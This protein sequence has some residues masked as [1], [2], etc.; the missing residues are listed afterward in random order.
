MS[1]VRCRERA[2]GRSAAVERRDRDVSVAQDE[3]RLYSVPARQTRLS[4]CRVQRHRSFAR[5]CVRVDQRRRAPASGAA[6]RH[7]LDPYGP[8][9]RQVRSRRQCSSSARR[10]R[11]SAFLPSS[12]LFRTSRC[13]HARHRSA[14][15]V[16]LVEATPDP[17]VPL[18]ADMAEMMASKKRKVTFVEGDDSL[19]L[20]MPAPKRTIS[21]SYP[22]ASALALSKPTPSNKMSLS[23]AAHAAASRAANAPRFQAGPLQLKRADSLSTS[24]A[25]SVKKAQTDIEGR[26]AS[27]AGPSTTTTTTVMTA[28]ERAS[29]RASAVEGEHGDEEHLDEPLV[30]LSMDELWSRQRAQ[31]RTLARLVAQLAKQVA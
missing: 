25:V 28:T 7:L 27:S 16:M 26:S 1:A 11:R 22:A 19:D 4:G 15:A 10:R 30:E 14:N 17:D 21:P 3:A 13:I 9:R 18:P 29:S 6:T 31:Q 23:E 5:P 12:C 2:R 24:S 20:A 8:D